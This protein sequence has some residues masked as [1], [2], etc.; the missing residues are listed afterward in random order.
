MSSSGF[1]NTIT[2]KD[3]YM[4]GNKVEWYTDQNNI[5]YTRD[6]LVHIITK[7]VIPDKICLS[8]GFPKGSLAKTN[9]VLRENKICM[10]HGK[11]RAHK[12]FNTKPISVVIED[13]GSGAMFYY[14]ILTRY[15]SNITFKFI[16]GSGGL[17]G[18]PK[19]MIKAA[20]VSNIILVI[21]D[22]KESDKRGLSNIVNTRDDLKR[23][24][25]DIF[26][27]FPL[28]V[29][30]CL[31][32]WDK[33]VCKNT[34]IYRNAMLNYFRTGIKPYRHIMN[35]VYEVSYLTTIKRDNNLER[36]IADELTNISRIK[37]SKRYL[38]YCFLDDC[39][40]RTINNANITCGNASSAL[41][42]DSIRNESIAGVLCDLIDDKIL[43]RGR[44]ISWTQSQLSEI[45]R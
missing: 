37:Y 3:K 29:E 31:I 7:S 6:Q 22:N 12:I 45:V 36:K 4:H 5:R 13:T 33:L 16:G 25:K 17:G 32:S 23:L 34:S 21:Y 44:K 28:S 41:K 19:R 42:I 26:E 39:C 20:E 15:F 40:R 9:L 30:T 1:V 8:Y 35:D 27:F 11:I 14:G 38:H 10:K 24:K 43:H 2:I 18:I